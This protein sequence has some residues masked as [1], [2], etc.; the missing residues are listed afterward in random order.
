MQPGNR[1]WTG[2]SRWRSSAERD[3]CPKDNARGPVS[4]VLSCNRYPEGPAPQGQPFIWAACRHA[5]R[6]ANPGRSGQSTP[7]RSLRK[8][9]ARPLFGL[10]PGGVYHAA[11]VT[12]RA[13]RSYRTFSPLPASGRYTFCCTFHKLT[14]PRCYLA[15]CPVEPG[16]SS[17]VKHASD[18]LDQLS[19]PTLAHP[20]PTVQNHLNRIKRPDST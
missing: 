18:C 13:V 12:N 11:V 15:L 19:P 7:A 5:A 8:P 10:A 1:S 20:S 2:C 3:R 6:A 9:G 4:R 14:L 16:L 17:N